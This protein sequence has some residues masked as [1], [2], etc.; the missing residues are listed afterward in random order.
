VRYL[1][2]LIDVLLPWPGRQQ[3][4][5]AI[6]DARR[7][8]ERSRSSAAHAAVIE[9]DIARMA[10]ANHFAQIIAGQIIRGREP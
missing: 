6:S 9:R 8:K 2:R 3:R 5:E 1:R 10:E 4:R 7:E